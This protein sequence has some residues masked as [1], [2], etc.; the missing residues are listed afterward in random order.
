MSWEWVYSSQERQWSLTIGEW[1]AVVRRVDG[2]RYLWRA[3]IERT[4]ASHD[5]YDGP[6]TPDAIAARTWC[7]TKIAELRVHHDSDT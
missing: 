6:T 7:L 1:Q 3:I 5:R 2:P 4:G